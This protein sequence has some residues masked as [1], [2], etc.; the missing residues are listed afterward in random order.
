MKNILIP[1][2]GSAS[3]STSPT[4]AEHSSAVIASTAPAEARLALS[5]DSL[6]LGRA[7][8]RKRPAS[9]GNEGTSPSAKR[10]KRAN[11]LEQAPE[12]RPA[13]LPRIA[14]VKTSAATSVRGE[15]RPTLG[16]D[17][18]SAVAGLL[19][20]RELTQLRS[21][22][23]ALSATASYA[24]DKLLIRNREDLRPALEAFHFNRPITLSADAIGTLIGDVQNLAAHPW[25]T[26]LY[27]S[28]NQIDSEGAV[29][30]AA[31]NS[32]IELDLSHNNIGDAGVRALADRGVVTELDMSYNS[33]GLDGMA[34]L[35]A[36]TSITRLGLDGCQV[37]DAMVG[38]LATNSNI[39]A[40]FLEDNRVGEMGLQGVEALA[41]NNSIQRL[42]LTRNFL[43]SRHTE[44]LGL[45]TSITQLN[46]SDNEFGGDAVVALLRNDIALTALNLD[47]IDIDMTALRVLASNRRIT[48]LSIAGC[49]LHPHHIEVLTTNTTLQRLNLECNELG[50]AGAAI[51]ARNTTIT[52]LRLGENDISNDG[53]EALA[54]NA[55]LTWLDLDDNDIGLRGAYALA[56]SPSLTHL[57]LACNDEIGDIGAEM[58]ACSPTLTSLNLSN[59]YIGD[60][61]ALALARNLNITSLDLRN[62]P[63]GPIGRHALEAERGRFT[64]LLLD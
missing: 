4:A 60:R 52:S 17:E 21:V 3:N 43:D 26:R 62:N 64:Q 7:P 1:S 57:N 45:S 19:N 2:S 54:A 18:W 42:E 9:E 29:A 8:E 38:V 48:S 61:G 16:L 6:A 56:A 46:L 37:T 55:T 35:A 49:D 30:L 32:L 58:L 5:A 20:R 47:K 40:L 22:N 50:D 41:S 63:I 44:V 14:E 31:S 51:I 36:N 12:I 33:I 23:K 25:L 34:A 10:A 59:N 13:D 28:H 53:A 27:A 15:G 24:I 11:S 39:T